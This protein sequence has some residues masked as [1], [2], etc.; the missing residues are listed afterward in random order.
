M[1]KLDCMIHQSLYKVHKLLLDRHP[2][3]WCTVCASLDF[4]A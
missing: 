4:R 1:L 3:P 2:F